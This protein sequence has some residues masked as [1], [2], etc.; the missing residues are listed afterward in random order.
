MNT[1]LYPKTPQNI[2]ADF[3]K[4]PTAYKA[5]AFYVL[6]AIVFFLVFYAGL[7][8][9][10]AYL[11]YLSVI[12]PMMDGGFYIILLK[13]GSIGGAV[14]L[15]I[16]TL[17]FLFKGAAKDNPANVEIK[18][19]QFPKLFAFI[20]QLC[21]DTGAPFPKKVIV[22]SEINAAVFYN[23]TVWSLFLPVRKNLLIGLGLVN[24]LNL[25]EFKAVLAH[26]FG[27][28]RQGSMKLGSYVY[29]ANSIIHD[30]VYSR[31][32]W[33]EMLEGWGRQ[34]FRIAIFAWALMPIVWLLRQTLALSF[35]LINLLNSSRQ[36]LITSFR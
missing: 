29:M 5:R 15:F 35:Q 12:Y 4:V 32:S 8:A 31:D 27:H 14:M 22:S 18:E 1:D 6:L 7:I 21:E 3:L 36:K 33:D 25:S 2:P 17:K 16:F 26:E 10:T 19:E 11:V 34:D 23:S 24:G 28:F 30:M 9:A 20:R 13:L